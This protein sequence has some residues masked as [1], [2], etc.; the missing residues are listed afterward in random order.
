MMPDWLVYLILALAVVLA[1][2]SVVG[3]TAQLM[4]WL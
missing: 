4:G 1:V 2:A 3:H